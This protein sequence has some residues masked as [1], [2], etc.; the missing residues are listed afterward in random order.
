MP[1]CAPGAVLPQRRTHTGRQRAPAAVRMQCGQTA[2]D[3][4]SPAA[5]ERRR[6]LLRRTLALM[7]CAAA[8]VL[9]PRAASAEG[10]LSKLSKRDWKQLAKPLLPSVV[11]LPIQETSF[12]PWLFGSWE[13]STTFAGFELPVKKL[14]K[15]TLMADKAIP[16][17]QKVST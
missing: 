12:P 16:G 15:K 8:D 14:S 11:A 13:V 10:L 4:W 7:T 17:F 9:S 2:E 3:S 5:S 6:M 1:G